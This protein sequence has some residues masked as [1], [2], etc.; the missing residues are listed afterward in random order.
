LRRRLVD[1]ALLVLALVCVWLLL[2]R[3]QVLYPGRV[4]PGELPLW[5]FLLLIAGL[6]TRGLGKRVV[7]GAP[8]LALERRWEWIIVAV[9][10][11]LLPLWHQVGGRVEGEGVQFYVYLRSMAFDGDLDFSNEYVAY[12]LDRDDPRLFARTGTGVPRNVHSVGPALM[13]APFFGLGHAVA[14]LREVPDELGNDPLVVPVL[15]DP[16]GRGATPPAAGAP[17]P[18]D[19]VL[20]PRDRE[21]PPGYA[22]PY[23]AAV[24]FGTIFWMGLAALLLFRELRRRMASDPAALA[25]MAT[26]LAGPLLWYTFFEPSMSH[27][28][29]AACLT[30]A[31]LAWVW[32]RRD[33][34]FISA[35]VVGATAGLLAMQRW[36]FVLWFAVPLIDAGMRAWR[37]RD[38]RRDALALVAQTGAMTSAVLVA[39]LPQFYAWKAVW[40]S[41][42]V[43]PMGGAYL[44]WAEP[45]LWQVLLSQRHG[46]FAWHPLMLVALLG[47]LLCWRRDRVVALVGLALFAVT[48]YVNASVIDWWGNDAFGQRRFAALYPFFAWGLAAVFVAVRRGVRQRVLIALVV[49]LIFANVGLAHGY[50]TGFVRRNWWVSGLDVVRSSAAAV[51]AAAATSLRWSAPRVPVLGA[52]LYDVVDGRY[53]LVGRGLGGIVDL[54]DP[55]DEIFVGAG[56]DRRELGDSGSY[57]WIVGHRATLWLPLWYMR[58]H[59]L[60]FEAWA[61]DGLRRQIVTV[62]INGESVDSFALAQRAS[63]RIRVEESVWRRGLNFV[64]I[65]LSAAAPPPTDDRRPLSAAVAE[66]RLQVPQ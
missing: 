13:W 17:A 61:L 42:V 19:V 21:T 6:I 30:F 3:G 35:V 25:V 2:S 5:P 1:G 56:W 47:L 8:E 39:L 24:A 48:W 43:N 4:E 59:D 62:R 40:G 55:S 65:T 53:L 32:W 7:E 45:A 27:A 66:I 37:A 46:L 28:P 52:W 22:Y 31:L 10:V 60:V 9:F 58:D 29:A 49:A 38:V 44:A 36:Q 63:R 41:W 18:D 14:T 26:I 12:G 15:G 64:E 34:G 11:A 16:G 54:G 33:P 23:V 20:A 51:E 50:R 57:R